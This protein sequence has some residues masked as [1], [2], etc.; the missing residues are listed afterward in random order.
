MKNK[1]YFSIF[2]I[3]CLIAVIVC[4]ICDLAISKTLTWSLITISAITFAWL[5]LLPSMMCKKKIVIAT[6][7]SLTIFIIPFLYILSVLIKNTEIL[8]IGSIMSVIGLIYLWS[9]V[10]IS[11][12]FKQRK[13]IVSSISLL[14]VIPVC[15]IVNIT[16]SK[17]I[18]E[19]I[20]DIWDILT[21]FILL[22]ISIILFMIDYYKSKK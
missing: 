19:P 2:T 22:I 16:L 18:L 4:A 20:I 17:M 14:L 3:I 15:L 6:L 21:I 13:Y 1:L 5:I 9:I 12:K 11:Q 10:G 7:L 8:S